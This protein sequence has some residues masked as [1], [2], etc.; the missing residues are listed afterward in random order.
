MTLTKKPKKEPK[1]D[2]YG[3]PIAREASPILA[4]VAA[5]S[6]KPAEQFADAGISGARGRSGEPS[7][8]YTPIKDAPTVYG[9]EGG[10]PKV[11]GVGE[12]YARDIG[13]PVRRQSVY[14]K[15]NSIS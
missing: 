11:V 5:A 13:I 14:A 15:A 7:L 2:I 3:K 1:I 9:F 6:N 8:E 10:A 4:R 12:N